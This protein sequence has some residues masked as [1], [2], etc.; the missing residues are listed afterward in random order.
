MITD[1]APQMYPYFIEAVKRKDWYYL[2]D[3]LL[4]NQL[5]RSGWLIN[6]STPH[7]SSCYSSKNIDYIP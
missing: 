4:K 1:A 2:R 6:G 5:Q 7:Q 3:F